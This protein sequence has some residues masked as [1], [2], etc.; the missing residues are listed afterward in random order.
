MDRCIKCGKV[1]LAPATITLEGEVRGE[2]YSVRMRGRVCPD[3]GYKTI[4]GSDMPEFA[5]L[6]SD[7]YR[8]AHGLLTSEEIRRRR[9][10]LG[11]SQ[12]Q[13]ANYLRVGV[14]SVKRWEMGKIQDKRLDDEIRRKTDKFR[15]T[16]NAE[17]ELVAATETSTNAFRGQPLLKGTSQTCA[18]SGGAV[19]L[20]SRQTTGPLCLAGLLNTSTRSVEE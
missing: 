3:D 13:L 4:E 1:E 12:Q 18:P 16:T 7:K 15:A 9:K 2:T 6:L 5:R 20:E 10:R 14:A 11:M 8:A 19:K 17:P